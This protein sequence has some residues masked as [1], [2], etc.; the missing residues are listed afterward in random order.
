MMNT[1]TTESV[2]PG[3]DSFT[4]AIDPAKLDAENRKTLGRFLD[5]D[6]LEKLAGGESYTVTIHRTNQNDQEW[7]NWKNAVMAAAFSGGY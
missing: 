1:Q 7:Q 3:Q 6:A 4:V 2:D 5:D